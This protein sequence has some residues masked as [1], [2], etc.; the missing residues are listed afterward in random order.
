MTSK[1]SKVAQS[2]DLDPR[3]NEIRDFLWNKINQGRDYYN[4]VKDE[5]RRK[6]TKLKQL[7][8]QSEVLDVMADALDQKQQIAN[9][10]EKIEDAELAIETT[11]MQTEAL[12]SMIFVRREDIDLYRKRFTLKAIPLIKIHQQL[13]KKVDYFMALDKIFQHYMVREGYFWVLTLYSKKWEE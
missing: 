2:L 1:M 6:E 11:Q 13:D 4:M 12:N 8:E 3:S 10:E 7:N 5:V 9:L